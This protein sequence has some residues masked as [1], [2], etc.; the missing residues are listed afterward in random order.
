[1]LDTLAEITGSDRSVLNMMEDSNINA[2]RLVIWAVQALPQQP[3]PQI[4]MLPSQ[5]LAW[6]SATAKEHGDF[7]RGW[8]PKGGHVCWNEDVGA[9][10]LIRSAGM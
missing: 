10:S 6:L 5:V 7:M 8:T 2:S 4:R 3:L 9:F 1:M